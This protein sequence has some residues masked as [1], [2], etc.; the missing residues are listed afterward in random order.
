MQTSSVGAPRRAVAVLITAALAV[1]GFAM[2]ASAARPGQYTATLSGSTMILPS[3]SDAS[4]RARV[5]V[6]RADDEIQVDVR[7]VGT[8]RVTSMI[9]RVGIPGASGPTVVEVP[10]RRCGDITIGSGVFSSDEVSFPNGDLDRLVEFL[11][12]QHISVTVYSED[13]FFG[14]IGGA[15]SSRASMSRPMTRPMSRPHTTID[16]PD[17]PQERPRCEVMSPPM[18][19]PM[20]KPHGHGPGKGHGK[21][22]TPPIDRPSPR[23]EQPGRPD[24]P[25]T[26]PRPGR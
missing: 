3:G 18:S 11:D 12:G 9:L 4:G 20:T 15:F 14:E 5:V 25:H 19:R 10:F 16:R 8:S 1:S 26:G 7:T 23:P 24:R 6:D 2:T 21:P 22:D 13:Y 17:R